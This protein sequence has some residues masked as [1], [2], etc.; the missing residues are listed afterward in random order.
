MITTSI[1]FD[2]HGRA[3]KG[4]LG[5]LEVRV[6]VDR[7]PY[8]IQTGIKVRKEEWKYGSIIGRADAL[9]LMERLGIVVKRIEEEINFAITDGRGISVADIRRRISE[10]VSGS[11]RRFIEWCQ[12]KVEGLD[13]AKGTKSHYRTMLVRLTQYDRIR[14]WRDLTAENLLD[15][16]R[17]LRELKGVDGNFILSEAARYNYHKCLKALLNLAISLGIIKENPYIRL[18]GKIKRGE[19]ESVEYLTE[20][21][22]R[23]IREVE[24]KPFSMLDNVRDLFVFQMYTGLSYSDMMKFDISEYKKIDGKWINRSERIKTGVPFVNQL[25]PPVVEI[26]EKRDMKLPF[27]SNQDYNRALKLLGQCAGIKIALHSHLARHTFATFM[28]SQGVKLE[29]LSK[30]LGH[31]KITQ[32]QRY[33]KILAKD[34]RNDFDMIAEKIKRE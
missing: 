10:N 5:M 31:T 14:T 8:Y 33:A 27:M 20:D 4:E 23:S 30:M 11:D 18:K 34:V 1:V 12:E 19:K 26:L 28:L 3:G 15:F 32:T 9:E 22:M 6:T 13:L 21:E 2:H 25:L 17:Y 16:D 7:K 29:N 24:L